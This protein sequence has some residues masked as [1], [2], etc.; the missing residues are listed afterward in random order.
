MTLGIGLHVCTAIDRTADGNL[1]GENCDQD[2]YSSMD[3]LYAALVGRP[4]TVPREIRFILNDSIVEKVD[5]GDDYLVVYTYPLDSRFVGN[6]RIEYLENGCNY[7]KREFTMGACPTAIVKPPI[8][9][10]RLVDLLKKF[11]T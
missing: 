9:V 4:A 6:F 8:E 3:V 1:E 2:T 7:W 5:C 10:S 11:R